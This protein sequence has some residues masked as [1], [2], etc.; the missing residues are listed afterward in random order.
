M[1]IVYLDISTIGINT[2]FSKIGELGTLTLFENTSPN[3]TIERIS[4]ADIIITSKVKIAKNEIDASSNLKA[5]MVSATGMDNIDVE[6]A[7]LKNIK[8]YNVTNYSTRSVAQITFSLIFSLNF[9]LISFNKYIKGKD[10]S[11]SGS[12][13]CFDFPFNELTN[14]TIGIVG[15]G[16][17]GKEV[18]RIASSFYM[19]II[20]YST[21]GLNATSDFKQVDFKQLLTKS[22]IVSLHCP[23]NSLTF[24]LM[25]KE[26][27]IYMK[28]T[29]L[30]INTA[31]GGIVN[32]SDLLYAL[33]NN[34]ISGAGLDVFSSEPLPRDS[35]LIAYQKSN[36]VLTPH[37]G[38]SSTNAKENLI[39]GLFNNIHNF[40]HTNDEK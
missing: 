35:P 13:S 21:S 27:F 32:E 25:N 31:R 16:A 15:M 2:D 39:N 12:P 30:L 26:A 23:L 34:I 40:I 8:V 7:K 1:N 19:N 3:Q 22:D 5:I 14:K 37:I 4:K 11:K 6:Y 33:E 24:N 18:A 17:I 10:Y 20:Y 36:L 29:A 9:H 28:A 38:W